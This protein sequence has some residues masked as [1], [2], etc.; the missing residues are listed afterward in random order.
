[1]TN[2]YNPKLRVYGQVIYYIKSRSSETFSETLYHT[3]TFAKCKGV[4][5]NNFS[6][7][8]LKN[9]S[10]VCSLY[11]KIKNVL[12]LTI[13]LDNHYNF[14]VIIVKL[15]DKIQ[16]FYLNYLE[17]ANYNLHFIWKKS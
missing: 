6:C 4:L 14:R 8:K 17:V 13:K 1:V 9:D 12:H 7:I 3:V 11:H 15:C 5:C 16:F 10:F 2:C